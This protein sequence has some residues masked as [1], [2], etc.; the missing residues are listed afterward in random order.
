MRLGNPLVV[1]SSFVK[2]HPPNCLKSEELSSLP[3]KRALTA[4]LGLSGFF[5]TQG[6]PAPKPSPLR[7][8]YA[9]VVAKCNC[10]P[11]PSI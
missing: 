8:A 11:N 5:Y 10:Q 1:I 7:Q 6:N 3:N 4:D 2:Q 9:A